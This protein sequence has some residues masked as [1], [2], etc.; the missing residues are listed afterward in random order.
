MCFTS[1]EQVRQPPLVPPATQP[2]NGA[3]QR[4]D[5]DAQ[6]RGPPAREAARQ[7]KYQAGLG[8]QG[9]GGEAGALPAPRS[10]G[11][12]RMR[13]V[14]LSLT[15]CPSRRSRT[16]ILAFAPHRFVPAHPLDRRDQGGCPLGRR[17]PRQRRTAS[18]L[19]AASLCSASRRRDARA[20]PRVIC[21]G[22]PK[23][24]MG[25]LL[26]AACSTPTASETPTPLSRT[27][28][29][30]CL[31]EASIECP[32]VR[33]MGGLYTLLDGEAIRAGWR[34]AP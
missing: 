33:F 3:N 28:S 5:R 15:A 12:L 6:G 10:I 27:A 13:P 19:R 1:P 9:P 23:V 16:A 29:H 26:H 32:K 22:R 34:S 25:V 30:F 7:A 20:A 24:C 14:V 11:I 2:V 8:R 31:N 21:R 18:R 4:D 17:A